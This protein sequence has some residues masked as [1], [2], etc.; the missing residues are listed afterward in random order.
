MRGQ[1]IGDKYG[2][3]RALKRHFE[4]HSGKKEQPAIQAKCRPNAGSVLI[5]EAANFLS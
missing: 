1:D 2:Q 4:T 3:K 5:D